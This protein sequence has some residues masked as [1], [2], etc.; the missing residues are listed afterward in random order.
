MQTWIQKNWVFISGL[1]SAIVV[2]LQQYTTG[3]PADLK[4]VGYA[5]VIAIVSY[6]AKQWEN[7]GLTVT[8]IIG[9][10]AA[11]F[12]T[13]YQTGHI[14]VSQLL[15]QAL[16]AFGLAATSK[17]KVIEMPNEKNVKKAA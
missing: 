8:G 9:T 5:V 6:V 17:G 4:V 14:E 10:L 2:V 11:T 1:I 7:Q 16:I 13:V 15:I 3:G 12:Y